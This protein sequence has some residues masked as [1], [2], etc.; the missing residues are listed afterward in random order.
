M[1][2]SKERRGRCLCGA[3][4]IVARSANNNVGACHCA[5]CRRWSSGPFMATDCGT[6][7]QI[8]GEENVTVFDSSPWAERGFCKKCGS[9]LFYRLKDSQ[10]YQMAV[11]LFDDAEH[12]VFKSQVFIDEK[13]PFY[14]FAN[15][16]EDLTGAEIFAMYGPSE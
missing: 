8:E 1:Q 15:E 14:G 16:T 6:D 11:G 10:E 4:K 12:L 5:M 2:N 9:N 3:V 13:P 7:V